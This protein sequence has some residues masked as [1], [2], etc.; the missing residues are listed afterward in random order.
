VRD[1]GLHTRVAK[2]SCVLGGRERGGRC[3]RSGHS[4]RC[5]GAKMSCGIDVSLIESSNMASKRAAGLK[6]GAY[7][8]WDWLAR[9]HPLDHRALQSLV[10]DDGATD[11]GSA[12]SSI[13]KQKRQHSSSIDRFISFLKTGF[14][15]GSLCISP[16]CMGCYHSGQDV[17]LF[18]HKLSEFLRNAPHIGDS[19]LV[20]D[21]V[22]FSRECRV[23][24]SFFRLLFCVSNTYI[25]VFTVHLLH[26]AGGVLSTGVEVSF[27]R[28]AKGLLQGVLPHVQAPTYQPLSAV[29]HIIP[30]IPQGS[31]HTRRLQRIY[32]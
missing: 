32:F 1:V 3:L 6:D 12:I 27:V 5:T 7:P 9:H 21:L 16:N 11:K 25:A 22:N 20:A 8:I 13:L 19:K 17:L 4:A 26:K 29:F 31:L 14:G 10:V 23:L 18:V 30:W 24:Q 28:R 15:G 2:E